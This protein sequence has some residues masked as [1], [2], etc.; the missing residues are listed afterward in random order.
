[1]YQSADSSRKDP[2]NPGARPCH[3]RRDEVLQLRRRRNTRRQSELPRLTSLSLC[4]LP[5]G[6]THGPKGFVCLPLQGLPPYVK[7]NR[8]HEEW[9]NAVPDPRPSGVAA[10]PDLECLRVG[11]Q[12]LCFIYRE[13]ADF[14][15]MDKSRGCPSDPAE[16]G[17]RRP[18]R[19]QFDE[20]EVVFSLLSRED[21]KHLPRRPD[22]AFLQLIAGLGLADCRRGLSCWNP[23][24][25]PL[26]S[27]ARHA[28]LRPSRLPA[29][30]F[31]GSGPPWDCLVSVYPTLSPSSDTG[32][33]R[34]IR[35]L[36]AASATACTV[37]IDLRNCRGT[38]ISPYLLAVLLV[39]PESIICKHYYKQPR[40]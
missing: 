24:I 26:G 18:F 23:G 14:P 31:G 15:G 39:K 7:R 28:R 2:R 9:R 3:L 19:M 27:R 16:N 35:P 13:L 11:G 4:L 21:S 10:A 17:R 32:A 33:D 40:S 38:A 25:D 22:L 5:I 34:K 29:S 36:A 37:P 6:E 1:M 8:P 30:G 12:R 20:S